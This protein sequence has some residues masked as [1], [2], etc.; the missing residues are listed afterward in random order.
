LTF[1]KD[2]NGL[3][4]IAVIA[5]VLFH[6]DEDFLS[7]G[8]AG[9]DVFFVISGFLMTSAIIGKLENNKFSLIGFYLARA[10]RI[11]PALAALCFTLLLFGYLFISPTDLKPLAKHAIS[12]VGFF[13]NFTYLRESGYFDAASNQKW[14]LHT[15]SLSVEW[16]F[17]IIYPI[18]IICITKVTPKNCLKSLLIVFLC[19]S[20]FFSLYSSYKW[21]SFAYFMLPTRAWEMLLGGVA[22]FATV[23]RTNAA[24]NYATYFG[25]SAI[26]C[27]YVI[28]NEST[29]WPGVAAALPTLG[30]YLVIVNHS[31]SLLLN[32]K[33][34]QK[35]GNWSYSIYLWHWPVVVSFY[36]F[37]IE[38]VFLPLGLVLSFVLGALSFSTVEQLRLA[39]FESSF[40]SIV[41]STSLWLLII[42][43]VIGSL[44][45]ITD[46]LIKSTSK[47]FRSILSE[48]RESP[49]RNKCHLQTYVNPESS[50]ILGNRKK[51]NWAILGDSHGTEIAFALSDEIGKEFGVQQFT[52]SACKPSYKAND[53]FSKCARWYNDTVEYLINHKE[54]SN[55]VITHRLTRYITGVDIYDH[56]NSGKTQIVSEEYSKLLLDNFRNI[57]V[58][59]SMAKD[60]VFIVA[61]IPEIPRHIKTLLGI[62]YKRGRSIKNIDGTSL[63]FY[64]ERNFRFLNFLSS[65]DSLPNVE[66]I[67]V[68]DIFCDTITCFAVRDGVPLYFDDDHPS[69]LGAKSIS[70]KIL[71]EQ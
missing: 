64:Y 69:V 36:Y 9:V 12:S 13:S 24:S 70:S 4:A 52:F 41:K 3:R 47:E 67:Y 11:V 55:V 56:Q 54:I 48:T 44:F 43:F 30:T 32:N 22:Y 21:P 68:E 35:I 60:K 6:F 66:I 57:I 65:Q 40:K 61:P 37:S 59:L 38:S 27:S 25:L 31:K 15:W 50:C 29:R 28:F 39:K 5:V 42:V 71:K 53:E 8:F 49:V 17:Y 18:L 1:R 10:N 23:K 7:G 20:F 58:E 16:Q 45:F 46:G 14:L 63:E 51:V 26:I 2:I 33:L 62:E 19:I 34:S